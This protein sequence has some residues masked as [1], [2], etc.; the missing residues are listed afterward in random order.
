[1]SR[2]SLKHEQKSVPSI[3]KSQVNQLSNFKDHLKQ[4][5]VYQNKLNGIGGVYSSNH[6]MTRPFVPPVGKHKFTALAQQL[7]LPKYNSLCTQHIHQE[8]SYN[9][10]IETHT[11]VV[12]SITY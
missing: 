6:S 4:T 9:C 8:R 7:L 3:H 12:C 2:N 5:S 1:M 11:T 10:I